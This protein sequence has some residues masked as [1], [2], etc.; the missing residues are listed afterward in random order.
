M[1]SPSFFSTISN[2]SIISPT[3]AMHLEAPPDGLEASSLESLIFAIQEHA[4]PQG[5]A[6]VKRRTKKNAKAKYAKL[7]YDVTV[8]QKPWKERAMGSVYTV[9]L[10]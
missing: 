5:Y 2:I 10:V 9:L 1:P 6:V 3:M 7:G 8:E 4:G